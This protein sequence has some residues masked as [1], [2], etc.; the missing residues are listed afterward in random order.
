MIPNHKLPRQCPKCRAQGVLDWDCRRCKNCGTAVLRE[1]DNGF[2]NTD[3]LWFMYFHGPRGL[4]WY[5]RGLLE[6][7]ELLER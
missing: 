2:A 4:G 6:S 3:E 5:Q 1:G 7:W